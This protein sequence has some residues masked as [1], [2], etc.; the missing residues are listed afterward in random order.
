MGAWFVAAMF[1]ILT[2]MAVRYHAPAT[3]IILFAVGTLIYGAIGTMKMI[4]SK[5]ELGDEP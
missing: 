5:S 2:A 1:T 3:T 4:Y